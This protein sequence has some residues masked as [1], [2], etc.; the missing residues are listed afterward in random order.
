MVYLFIQV[1]SES[2]TRAIALLSENLLLIPIDYTQGV[3]ISKTIAFII[4]LII[5]SKIRIRNVKIPDY[6]TYPLLLI[7]FFSLMLTYELYSITYILDTPITYVKYLF[8]VAMLIASNLILFYLL[9]KNTELYW[10]KEKM[11]IQQTLLAEQKNYY[12]NAVTMYEANRQLSHDFKNHLLLLGNYIIKEQKKEALDYINKLSST[13]QQNSIL[14]SGCSTIDAVLSAKKHLAGTQFTEFHLIELSLPP[15]IERIENQ[16]AL[17]LAASLDNALEATYKIEDSQSRWINILLR[18]DETYLYLQIENSTAEP[19]T[20]SNNTIA[21]SK[22]DSQNHGLGLPS[23]Q[24]LVNELQG[25]LILHYDNYI[26]SIT[27]MFKFN[28]N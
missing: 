24:N 17:I 5:T 23:I 21:T 9:E 12:K 20:I 15:N 16:V 2:F 7:P 3:V 13:V 18:H 4:I 25:K 19:V 10:L 28:N 14:Y 6:L 1:I 22:Q 27:I 8:S 26:F 11:L